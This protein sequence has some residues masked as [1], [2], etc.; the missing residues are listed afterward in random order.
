MGKGWEKSPSS[1]DV[2][3]SKFHGPMCNVGSLFEAGKVNI[4]IKEMTGMGPRDNNNEQLE[5][6][7]MSTLRRML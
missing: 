5:A 7:E 6:C 2:A 3:I 4:S 1:F